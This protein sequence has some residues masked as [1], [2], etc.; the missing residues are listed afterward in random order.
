MQHKLQELIE[1]VSHVLYGKDL[2]IQQAITCLITGGHLLIEDLPG[3]GKTTLAHALAKVLGLDYQRVQFTSDMLPADILGVSI[4]NANQSEFVFHKGPI[5][6][7]LLLAD[8]INRTTPKTQSALLEAMEERQ[9]TIESVTYALP[10]PFFV[11]ATQN[12]ISQYGTFP[13]PESQLDRFLMRIQLGYPSEA[14]E[15]ELLT[16]G[17]VRQKISSL[18]PCVSLEDLSQIRL[19]C[20]EVK[21]SYSVLDYLQRIVRYTRESDGFEYGISPRGSLA[22]LNTAKAWAYLH[23]REFVLPDDIQMLL[24][25]VIAHRLRAATVNGGEGENPSIRKI[26][27]EV[28]VIG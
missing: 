4:F 22:L 20:S 15:R 3:M 21:V 17:D 12:P 25:P 27:T 7:Q 5:F 1:S 8:E 10:D 9:V 26:L 24:E 19:Q 11:I 18:K 23:N 13:L 28:D 6:T 16:G 2:Q 14:A